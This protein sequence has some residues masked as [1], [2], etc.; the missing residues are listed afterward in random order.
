MQQDYPELVFCSRTLSK[1]VKVFDKYAQIISPSGVADHQ[2][3]G[4]EVKLRWIMLPSPLRA[5]KF[6]NQVAQ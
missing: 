4:V 2:S 1:I 5:G 3:A 6:A